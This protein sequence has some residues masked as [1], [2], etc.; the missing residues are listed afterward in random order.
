MTKIELLRSTSSGLTGTF[1]NI[2]HHA[3][4]LRQL[5]IKLSHAA[6]YWGFV[7]W[8]QGNNVHVFSTHDNRQFVFRPYYTKENG[9]IGISVSAKF[10]RSKE[11]PLF[12]VYYDQY[13]L[14]SAI[15]KIDVTMKLLAKSIP[16]SDVS[17]SLHTVEGS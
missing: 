1:Q 13:D 7:K 3:K 14:D 12:V 2:D 8:Q 6:N 17:P 4:K 5:V 15:S 11:M 10:S 9:Y 16:E